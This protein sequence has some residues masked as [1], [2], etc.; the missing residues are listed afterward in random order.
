MGRV[1]PTYHDNL[2][3]SLTKTVVCGALDRINSDDDAPI[4]G[5]LFPFSRNDA[6]ERR[7]RKGA[8]HVTFSEFVDALHND[9][10]RSNTMFHLL[11]TLVEEVVKK[12]VRKRRREDT[13][14]R[15]PDMHAGSIQ[16]HDIS[17]FGGSVVIRRDADGTS[18]WDASFDH[19]IERIAAPDDEPQEGGS[20]GGEAIGRNHFPSDNLPLLPQGGWSEALFSQNAVARTTTMRGYAEHKYDLGLEEWAEEWPTVCGWTTED[21]ELHEAFA[22]I[23]APPSCEIL[24]CPQGRIIQIHLQVLRNLLRTLRVHSR[25]AL[26]NLDSLDDISAQAE[27]YGRILSAVD[28]PD[29]FLSSVGDFI[30][31]QLSQDLSHLSTLDQ[32]RVSFALLDLFRLTKLYLIEQARL[33]DAEELAHGAINLVLHGISSPWSAELPDRLEP[34]CTYLIRHAHHGDGLF[35]ERPPIIHHEPLLGEVRGPLASPTWRMEHTEEGDSDSRMESV[36]AALRAR[37]D[38]LRALL[39]SNP[40]HVR[41]EPT[42]ARVESAPAA[43][44]TR[45]GIAARFAAVRASLDWPHRLSPGHSDPT[46]RSQQD[47]RNLPVTVSRTA[48]AASASAT[49]V[50]DADAAIVAF[51]ISTSSNHANG[52]TVPRIPSV[53]QSPQAV[54]M[55]A[56]GLRRSGASRVSPRNRYLADRIDEFSAFASRRRQGQRQDRSADATTEG[57]ETSSSASITDAQR[58]PSAASPTRGPIAPLP[59]R[60]RHGDRSSERQT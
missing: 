21:D 25:R 43:T 23:G 55:A 9:D 38:M 7:K 14:R 11:E 58:P 15:I 24:L 36:F 34:G 27:L 2:W 49:A 19:V 26:E 42:S 6:P 17:S 51:Q 4:E 12:T 40:D 10:K 39:G 59:P 46:D 41:G 50:I 37:S 22:Q 47:N 1:S 45:Y 57:D 5:Q 28:G 30:R 33:M 3:L 13:T 35:E 8:N 53:N 48:P 31:R 18:P 16:A 52:S 32:M 20:E 54:A 56:N 44:L 29:H 60:G